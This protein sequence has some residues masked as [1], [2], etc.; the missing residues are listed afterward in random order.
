MPSAGGEEEVMVARLT[1][2]YRQQGFPSPQLNIY[3]VGPWRWEMHLFEEN[4][5]YVTRT[6]YGPKWYMERVAT[7]WLER[8]AWL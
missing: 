2:P 3:S 5:H 7:S 4:K 1:E 8:E 6:V